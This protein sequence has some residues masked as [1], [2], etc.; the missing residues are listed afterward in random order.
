MISAKLELGPF[1]IEMGTPTLN[2]KLKIMA[3]DKKVPKVTTVR[4]CPDSGVTADIIKE[5]IP[6]SLWCKIKE[7]INNT[8]LTTTDQE[9]LHIIEVT[10]IKLRLPSGSREKITYIMCPK[11]SDIFLLSWFTQE[12][13]GV[14]F[15]SWPHKNF[16]ANFFP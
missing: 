5:S 4:V 6:I 9:K 16:S 1:H 13:L 2:I 7:N 3:D 12:I 8:K 11:L 14:L 10:I 15:K